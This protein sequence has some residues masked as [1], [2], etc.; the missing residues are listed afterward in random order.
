MKIQSKYTLAA[1][2]VEFSC[3]TVRSRPVGC[4][5]AERGKFGLGEGPQSISLSLSVRQ[6]GICMKRKMGVITL[7]SPGQFKPMFEHCQYV[8][9]GFSHLGGANVEQL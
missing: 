2:A 1:A 7:C 9:L 5:A 6:I 3:K 4:L 8:C